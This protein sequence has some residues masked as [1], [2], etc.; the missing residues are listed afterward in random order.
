MG[1]PHLMSSDHS[2]DCY[3]HPRQA[4]LDH[5]LGFQSMSRWSG[6]AA[7]KEG[8]WNTFA[9]LYGTFSPPTHWWLKDGPVLLVLIGLSR[10]LFSWSL[11]DTSKFVVA[12]SILCQLILS[13]REGGSFF[14]SAIRWSF[15]LSKGLGFQGH[16]KLDRRSHDQGRAHLCLL[17]KCCLFP[18]LLVPP[19]GFWK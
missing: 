18:T 3:H 4:R 1:S 15:L 13:V 8:I 2:S 10:K 16:H 17:K 12:T 19:L 9:T 6:T 11:L 7:W 5:R 14:C